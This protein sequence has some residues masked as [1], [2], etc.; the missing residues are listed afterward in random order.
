MQGKA[1]AA[2]LVTNVNINNS[3]TEETALVSLPS[4]A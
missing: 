3:I 2:D 1:R 4:R